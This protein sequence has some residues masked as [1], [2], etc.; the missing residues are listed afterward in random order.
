VAHPAST[1]QSADQG[2]LTNSGST[3]V[4]LNGGRPCS[5]TACSADRVAIAHGGPNR[6][7]ELP[8]VT[9]PPTTHVTLPNLCDSMS[10]SSLP[11]R[12]L[13]SLEPGSAK[14]DATGATHR[15]DHRWIG[16]GSR[17]LHD[18]AA[19]QQIAKPGAA[20]V[21]ASAADLLATLS[22]SIQVMSR[23]GCTTR[24][25]RSLSCL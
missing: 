25:A 12:K 7:D 9:S 18:P 3:S 19:R 10:S 22:D 20:S 15:S 6:C 1:A 13:G 11:N 5:P 14:C 17:A 16:L 24:S 8:L 4:P 23:W 2:S 21:D